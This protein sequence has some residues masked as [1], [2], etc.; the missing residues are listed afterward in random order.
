MKYESGIKNNE[1]N[2][3]GLFVIQN[4]SGGRAQRALHHAKRGG[5]TWTRTGDLTDVNGA[6]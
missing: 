6:L 2:H 1:R 4:Y 5:R 3:N